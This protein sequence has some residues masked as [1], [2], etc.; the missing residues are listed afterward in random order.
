VWGSGSPFSKKRLKNPKQS[1]YLLIKMR[2][3]PKRHYRKNHQSVVFLNLL[4]VRQENS[5]ATG[6][7]WICKQIPLI[8]EV[9]GRPA[10]KA[11][12]ALTA[13]VVVVPTV[14]NA[15]VCVLFSPTMSSTV[16]PVARPVSPP[17]PATKVPVFALQS[18]KSATEAV[19]T[20]PKTANI[21]GHV[22]MS[23][24][25]LLIVGAANASVKMACL[26]AVASVSASTQTSIIVVAV[27]NN[28][29]K[30]SCA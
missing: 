17:S 28:A 21:A 22:E 18:K 10:Q 11:K 12:S 13:V 9:V 3:L 29:E 5:F 19:L 2:L 16:V 4:S 20:P 26:S 24:H 7:V 30:D 6:V 23:V 27:E 14:T 8:A 1:L 25:R 15:T